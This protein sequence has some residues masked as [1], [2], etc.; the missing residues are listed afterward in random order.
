[1]SIRKSKESGCMVA[2]CDQCFDVVD[3]EDLDGSEAE[4]WGDVRQAIDIDGWKSKKEGGQWRN[5][6][7]DCQ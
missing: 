1:M 6:C 5:I 2:Q 4:H 7:P 3:F